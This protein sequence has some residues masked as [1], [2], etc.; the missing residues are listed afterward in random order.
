MKKYHKDSYYIKKVLLGQVQFY[1]PLVE[2]HKLMAYNLAFRI[3]NDREDAEEVAQDAFIKVYKSLPKFRGEAKF[4]TWLYKIIYHEALGKLRR[5]KI[6]T[7]PI[8]YN[9]DNQDLVTI[10]DYLSR[11][12]Q[13]TRQQYIEKAMQMLAEDERLILNL[14][15]YSETPIKEIVVITDYTEANVKIKL[16]RARKQLK[17]YLQGLLKEELIDLL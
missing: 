3:V 16:F 10:N 8:E 1:A 14:F 6:N 7:S 5:K 15:Y 11:V 17:K 13:E 2:K 12:K 4:S 9:E